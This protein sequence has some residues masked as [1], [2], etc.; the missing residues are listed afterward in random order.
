VTTVRRDCMRSQ[1]RRELI[2]R[3]VDGTYRPGDRLVEL[4]IA[5]E[6]NTSQAPVREAL[7]ELEALR[8]VE[9]ESYR[10]T[11]VRAISDRER[12]EAAVV[13]GVLEE[14]AARG[15]VETLQCAIGPLRHDY[16]ALQ[17]AAR[18]G[19]HDAYA[20]HN[21]AFHRRI[22][23][24]AGNHVMFRV[25]DALMIEARTRLSLVTFAFDLVAVAASH[26]PIVE[27]FAA[28]D[29]DRAGR[30]LREHAESLSAGRQP[31]ADGLETTVP[32]APPTTAPSHPRRS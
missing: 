28:G 1:I 22:V 30:L 9:T 24:A 15:G 12:W 14:A 16:E 7:R 2:R 19:D 27:A 29:G 11:R 5:H 21:T 26:G 4:Q 32:P 3:I 18:C 25:W 31:A 23:E 8:L 17:A 20:R 13:R 10:G 6:F